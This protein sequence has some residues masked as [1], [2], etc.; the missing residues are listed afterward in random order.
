VP[1][2]R[3]GAFIAGVQAQIIGLTSGSN[4][5]ALA[6][7]ANWFAFVGLALDLIG[8]SSGVARALLLQAAM[9]R[10][11]RLAT[12]LTSQ[13]DGA[14]HQLRQQQ[15]RSG[16][17]LVVDA[18]ASAALADSVRAISNVMALLAEDGRF[19][20]QTAAHISDIKVAGELA[21]ETLGPLPRA[22]ARPWWR[23]NWREHAPQLFRAL[24]LW[25]VDLSNVHV[26]GIGHIPVASLGGGALCLLTSV[27]LFAAGS[28]ERAVWISCTAISVSMLICSIMPTTSVHSKSTS[29]LIDACR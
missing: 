4:R 10:T 20:V 2:H 5:S 12:H 26:E 1:W 25:N 9:R 13:I 3:Q 8:T 18:Y 24:I 23:F 21:L 17:G 22:R 19:G 7:A 11:H 29:V 14:R 16:S 27:V 6:R 15:L 28:Q